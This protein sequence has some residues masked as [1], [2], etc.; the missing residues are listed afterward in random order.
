MPGGA[1]GAVEGR[2]VKS[3]IVPTHTVY[4]LLEHLKTSSRDL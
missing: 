2:K 3:L 1:C 4:E